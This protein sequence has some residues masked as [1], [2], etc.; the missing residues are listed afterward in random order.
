MFLGTI[1]YNPQT[2]PFDSD[3]ALEALIAASNP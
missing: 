2:N 1:P 3:K